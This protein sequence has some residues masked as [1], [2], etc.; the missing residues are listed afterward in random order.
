MSGEEGL[1]GHTQNGDRV[2]TFDEVFDAFEAEQELAPVISYEVSN[3]EE[4]CARAVR[5]AGRR[6]RD[7]ARR[8]SL[9]SVGGHERPEFVGRYSGSARV[10]PGLLEREYGVTDEQALLDGAQG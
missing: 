5:A 6:G 2:P 10:T 7:E 3:W 9:D 4:D 1:N 8:G